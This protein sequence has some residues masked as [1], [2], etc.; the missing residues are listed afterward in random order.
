MWC[1]AMW[2]PATQHCELE[3]LPGLSFLHCAADVDGKDCQG[4]ACD[5]V[6]R[7]F[8]KAPETV[9]V[10]AGFVAVVL[11]LPPR[12]ADEAA[13]RIST[14]SSS[15][16]A[17]SVPIAAAWRWYSAIAVPIRGPSRASC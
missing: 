14:F 12:L 3:K 9:K 15:V 13:F 16:E 6:E 1:L 4:D 17:M 7:G 8:Y 11:P 5:V 2:L 10:V